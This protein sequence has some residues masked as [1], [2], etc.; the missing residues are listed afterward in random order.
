MGFVIGL[1]FIVGGGWVAFRGNKKAMRLEKYDFENTTDGGTV[2][3]K[4]FE[5]AKRHE[6][7][8]YRA[9][10]QLHTGMTLIAIGCVVLFFAFLMAHF[11]K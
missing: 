6:A 10:L 3:F 2:Q 5:D 9:T 4:T 7:R 8:Q 1:M 11:S